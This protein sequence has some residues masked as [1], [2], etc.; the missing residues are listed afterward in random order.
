MA[1]LVTATKLVR[2]ESQRG[3]R[4]AIL[5][6]DNNQFYAV[7]ASSPYFCFEADTEKEARDKG[8]RALE[9]YYQS[10]IVNG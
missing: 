5:L 4:F 8:V 1:D 7:R 9:F 3:E 2:N 10:I 6:G